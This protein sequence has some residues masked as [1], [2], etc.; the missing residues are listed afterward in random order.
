MVAQ[1]VNQLACARATAFP[2]KQAQGCD[3][4]GGDS[5]STGPIGDRV[6]V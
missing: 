3:R 5:G 1:R 2:R 6:H 4:P